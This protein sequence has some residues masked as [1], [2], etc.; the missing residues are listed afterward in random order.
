[1]HFHLFDKRPFF[2]CKESIL[3]DFL[4][5]LIRCV[6]DEYILWDGQIRIS[7]QFF[8]ILCFVLKVIFFINLLILNLEN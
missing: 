5:L 6:L 1:M 4:I 3:K 2:V 8:G 7:L